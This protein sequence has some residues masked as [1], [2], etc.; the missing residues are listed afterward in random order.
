[1][2]TGE[3]RNFHIFKG[4]SL[5]SWMSSSQGP[6]FQKKNIILYA[7]SLENYESNVV[8]KYEVWALT[9]TKPIDLC[10]LT[11]GKIRECSKMNIDQLVVFSSYAMYRHH[12]C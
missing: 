12:H 4:K 11:D 7:L 8:F 5:Y 3:K 9:A 6:K 1:M 2:K 10:S